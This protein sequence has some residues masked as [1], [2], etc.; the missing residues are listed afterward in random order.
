MSKRAGYGGYALAILLISIAIDGILF[1]MGYAD[2]LILISLP[3]ILL[4]LYTVFFSMF[5]ADWKYYLIWGLVM[6]CL[7]FSL[8]LTLFTG[9]LL[10]NFSISLII[11]VVTGVIISKV[12]KR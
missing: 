12:G 1:S 4:G 11:I 6:S 5:A 9:N 3:L 2:P 8:F 7:G 10:L